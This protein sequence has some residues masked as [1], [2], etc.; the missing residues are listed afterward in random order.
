[1][2]DESREAFITILSHAN[3]FM[4][5]KELGDALGLS[6]RTIYRY[7]K[8]FN[9]DYQEQGIYIESNKGIGYRLRGM[10]RHPQLFQRIIQNPDRLAFEQALN[11][12][13]GLLVAPGGRSIQEILDNLY[14]SETSLY[15][16]I[17][18]SRSILSPFGLALV[19]EDKTLTIRGQEDKICDYLLKCLCENTDFI[20]YF[21]CPYAV[22]DIKERIKTY[23]KEVL[24][25][26]SFDLSLLTNALIICMTRQP[27]T[28]VCVQRKYAKALIALGNY[29]KLQIED[30]HYFCQVIERI[31]VIN[32]TET[33]D[34]VLS[35]IH[36]TLTTFIN[37]Y[38][39]LEQEKSRMVDNLLVHLLQM[40]KRVT[41]KIEQ[42]NPYLDAIKHRYPLEYNLAGLVCYQMNESIH[43]TFTEDEIAYIALYLV[44]IIRQYDHKDNSYK[45]LIVCEYGLSTGYLLAEELKGHFSEFEIQDV[46]ART[47]LS[48]QILSQVDLVIATVPL[49]E[50]KCLPVIVV[51]QL[52]SA[53]SLKRIAKQKEALIHRKQGFHQLFDVEP[54]I[55]E[56]KD[57]H[58]ALKVMLG[59]EFSSKLYAALIQR[60][61]VAS[62][63]L[64]N[65]VA[66][67]HYIGDDV[68]QSMIRV[69]IAPQGMDWNGEK[70]SLVFL[71]LFNR[72][73]VDLVD[74]FRTLYHF[75]ADEELVNST[76]NQATNRYI[77]T[78]MKGN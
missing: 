47:S 10:H 57:Y 7:V 50:V 58:E 68:E 43:L 8:Q 21:Y 4:T 64:G 59:R 32:A 9:E 16:L 22:T 62:T 61:T 65:R 19:Q 27:Y 54:V 55:M 39:E 66:F 71:A 73:D 2:I 42:I 76:I 67:P 20:Q 33:Q 45:V 11:H 3:S 48:P 70:V 28:N 24:P 60:E 30:L 78:F 12:L 17:L 18:K 52:F 53:A 37:R 35:V 69:G 5:A 63:A 36:Q 77:M 6:K 41:F 34:Q 25:L 72:K 46:I 38:S 31:Q 15:R 56:T 1:M 26:P 29:Y 40:L 51:D 13:I 44:T 14:C 23:F 75:C 49:E 74:V